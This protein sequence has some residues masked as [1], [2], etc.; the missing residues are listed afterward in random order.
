MALLAHILHVQV[1]IVALSC[2]EHL[3]SWLCLRS[4]VVGDYS[5]NHA[6]AVSDG[7]RLK[8]IENSYA[9]TR[10]HCPIAAAK[11]TSEFCTYHRVVPK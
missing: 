1:L 7:S 10:T 9:R 11:H 4:F 8:Q 3:F 6:Y 5:Y 2:D